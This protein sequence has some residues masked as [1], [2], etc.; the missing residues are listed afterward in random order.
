MSLCDLSVNS[1]N[2][3]RKYSVSNVNDEA[4]LLDVS[5]PKI[6]F[7]GSVYGKQQQQVF[8]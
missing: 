6:Y 7:L 2:K 8:T 1:L 4:F 5:I 3:I